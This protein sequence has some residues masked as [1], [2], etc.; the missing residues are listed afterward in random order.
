MLA[1]LKKALNLLPLTW[2]RPQKGQG[3]EDVQRFVFQEKVRGYLGAIG[4]Q[5]RFFPLIDN[6]TEETAEIRQAYRVMLRDPYVKAALF[7]KVLAVASLDPQVQPA[8][9]RPAD[10]EAAM[11]EFDVPPAQL[12]S[13][14]PTPGTPRPPNFVIPPPTA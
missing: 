14:D 6:Y 10:V 9:E 11:R 1:G 8:S 7:T 4:N 13:P 2:L 3:K 5:A 12:V